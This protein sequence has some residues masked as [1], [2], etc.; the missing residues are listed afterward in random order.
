MNEDLTITIGCPPNTDSDNITWDTDDSTAGV[1]YYYYTTPPYYHIPPTTYY[2][3]YPTTLDSINAKVEGN[4]VLIKNL[5]SRISV[6]EQHLLRLIAKM[7][8]V[9][10]KVD[11]NDKV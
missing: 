6:I 9:L 2:Y 1:G 3:H 11:N 10:A 5:E 4:K 7:D 8:E